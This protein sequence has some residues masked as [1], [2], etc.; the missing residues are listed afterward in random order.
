MTVYDLM[1]YIMD[2]SQVEIYMLEEGKTVFSGDVSDIP[3]NL[4]VLEVASINPEENAIV[5]NIQGNAQ[6]PFFLPYRKEYKIM[7]LEIKYDIKDI[8]GH[9]QMIDARKYITEDDFPLVKEVIKKMDKLYQ[10]CPFMFLTDG[11]YFLR[12][13]YDSLISIET[14]M[15]TVE[16]VKLTKG[17]LEDVRWEDKMP[18]AKVYKLVKKALETGLNEDWGI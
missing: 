4:T 3:W 9:S 10:Q 6:F 8:L 11:E 16:L 18:R 5:I 17:Y 12:I 15:L 1:G 14:H 13:S 7:E 2:D